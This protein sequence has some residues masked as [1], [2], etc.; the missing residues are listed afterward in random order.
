VRSELLLPGGRLQ[1][2][3][4][5]RVT[6][7]LGAFYAQSETDLALGVLHADA[8]LSVSFAHAGKLSPR[9][10]AHVQCAALYT[11][12]EGKR[13]VRVLNVA[14]QVAELAGNVFRMAD[15]DAVVCHLAKDGE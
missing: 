3:I 6:G 11:S 9:E 15:M 13:R 1:L 7:H 5:L 10:H 4:G 8:A 12:A 2:S 14:V